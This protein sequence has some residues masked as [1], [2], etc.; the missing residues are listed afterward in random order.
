M[1]T[2]SKPLRPRWAWTDAFTRWTGRH[3]SWLAALSLSIILIVWIVVETMF[4]GYLFVLQPIF[5]ALG[6]MMLG[7]VW[8]PGVRN[9]YAEQ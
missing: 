7:L 8:L 3:W 4:I 2:Q 5:G 6:L 1:K 9:Y